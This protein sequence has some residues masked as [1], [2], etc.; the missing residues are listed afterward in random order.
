V[1]AMLFHAD[2]TGEQREQSFL[3][4]CCMNMSKKYIFVPAVSFILISNFPYNSEDLFFF[5]TF[6]TKIKT[7]SLPSLAMTGI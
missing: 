6:S 1:A 7:Q 2:L 4:N 3:V 5:Y